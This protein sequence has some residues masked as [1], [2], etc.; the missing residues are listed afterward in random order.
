MPN[1]DFSNAIRMIRSNNNITMQD[2]ANKLGVTKGAV[3][4]WENKGVVPR[5]DILMKIS[6]EY[7]I[8]ID[9]LLGNNINIPFEEN[10]KKLSYLQRNLGNLDDK[11]LEKAE[12][13]L[14]AVF[15][16]LFEDD[17]GDGDDDI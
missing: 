15:N 4:M 2:L 17:E 5:E 10:N 1:K 3:N 16:D 7:N 6:N 9:K 12:Q 11:Q 13:V 8:S 14:K